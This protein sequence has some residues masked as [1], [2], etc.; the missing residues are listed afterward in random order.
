VGPELDGLI[1]DLEDDSLRCEPSAAVALEHWL[2]GPVDS[3]ADARSRLRSFRLRIRSFPDAGRLD[4][5][6]D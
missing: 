4:T 1:A 2:D 3:D 5:A 6:G